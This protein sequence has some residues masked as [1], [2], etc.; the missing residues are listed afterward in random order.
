[1]VDGRR[2]GIHRGLGGVGGALVLGALCGF[3][4][5]AGAQADGISQ[6]FVPGDYPTIQAALDAENGEIVVA[7]GV[8]DEQLTIGNNRLTSAEGAGVTVIDGGGGPGPTVTVTGSAQISGF[9][10]TGGDSRGTEMGGGIHVA[11]GGF[12]TVFLCRI[13]GNKADAGGGMRVEDPDDG[14][15][16]G[17]VGASVSSCLFDHNEAV[18]LVGLDDAGPGDGLGVVGLHVDGG[19]AL[20]VHT[21]DNISIGSCTFFENTAAGEG[22]AI[23]LLDTIASMGRL[24]FVGNTAGFGG[25]FSAIAL[26]GLGLV[27]TEA[28]FEDNHAAVQGGAV[29]FFGFPFQAHDFII[30]RSRFTGNS[31]GDRGGAVAA[32]MDGGGVF[33][34]K[35]LFARN[36]AGTTGAALALGCGIHDLDRVTLADNTAGFGGAIDR[37]RSCG[38]G[39]SRFEVHSSVIWEEVPFSGTANLPF[40]EDSDVKGGFGGPDN[41]NADPLFVAPAHLGYGL[42]Q[43]SP[44]IDAGAGVLDPDGSEPDMGYRPSSNYDD[45]GRGRGAP[46]GIPRLELSGRLFPGVEMSLDMFEGLRGGSALL[47]AGLS[48][49]ELPLSSGVLVP[50]PTV[51]IPLP[52]NADGTIHLKTAWP[53]GVPEG[54]HVFVQIWIDDPAGL[55]GFSSTNAQVIDVFYGEAPP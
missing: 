2:K 39:L 15:A 23:L 46:R 6:T 38:L 24:D 30:E 52:I 28:T 7:P 42:G 54:I 11:G 49:G 4:P 29:R 14:K 26:D 33:V 13:T 45:L 43:D 53:S 27:L 41:I 5:D 3:A 32:F 12:A 34:R 8:Y 31:A 9:T 18:G 51:S 21:E 19:G 48:A 17:A 20:F 55:D 16:S 35:S 10:I 37:E 1:M 22:G 44:C 40:V 25:A 47:F 36:T 50:S